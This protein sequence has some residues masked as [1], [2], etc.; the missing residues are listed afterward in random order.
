MPARDKKATL[1]ES[2]LLLSFDGAQ[3]GK[4]RE[5]SGGEVGLHWRSEVNKSTSS[6]IEHE[7]RD[8]LRTF[9]QLVGEPKI[10]NQGQE[11]LIFGG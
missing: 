2:F 10:G 9:F 7:Q 8:P 11:E 4:S 3:S 1:E 5:M 6:R